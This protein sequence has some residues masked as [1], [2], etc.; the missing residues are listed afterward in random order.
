MPLDL[1]FENLLAATLRVFRT[2]RNQNW[3]EPLKEE[4]QRE[5]F[6]SFEH[7]FL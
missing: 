2:E 5:F 3:V 4:V 7:I 1:I 6:I